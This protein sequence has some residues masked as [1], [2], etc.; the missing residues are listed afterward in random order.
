MSKTDFP[1]IYLR[2]PEA[3][4]L[5]ARGLRASISGKSQVPMLQVLYKYISLLSL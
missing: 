4:E 2:M 3:Q 5:Q 1:D